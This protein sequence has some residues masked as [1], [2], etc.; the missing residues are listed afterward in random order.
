[1]STELPFDKNLRRIRR[2]RAALRFHDA[3]YLHRLAADELVERLS[4]VRWSLSDALLLGFPD[5]LRGRL[6]EM[7]LVVT[8]ADPG[9]RF[10]AG[11]VQCDEDR[12]PFADA[13]FDLVVSV[14]T[15]DSV[16]DL[17]GALR[18]VRRALR[19]DGLFLAAFAGAG[20][21]PQLRKAMLDADATRGTASPR[22]HPQIDVRAAG[23][24]LTRAGFVLSAADTETTIVR[25]SMLPRLLSDLRGMAATNMMVQRA[26]APIG[27]KGFAA[28][29]HFF[30]VAA[31]G[32]GRTAE[33]FDL[34]YMTGWAPSAP[35]PIR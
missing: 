31:E 12:L 23:D 28:A 8:A 2:D 10:A 29:A 4:L 22:I 19:P 21:L 26:R 24:L 6:E 17:P 32:D 20:S 15:L 18:L 11:G 5:L 35:E 25:F 13:S 1:M 34:I 14:G 7:G 30:A 3:D 33:R 27:R 16:N 9:R